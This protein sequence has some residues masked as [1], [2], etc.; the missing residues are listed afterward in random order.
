MRRTRR[1]IYKRTRRVIYK[2][3]YVIAAF[4]VVYIMFQIYLFGSS[5]NP[6]LERHLHTPQLQSIKDPCRRK[7][8][9][10]DS[11]WVAM[12]SWNDKSGLHSAL[13]SVLQ[14]RPSFS[15]VKVVVF[16]DVSENMFSLEEKAKYPSV[17]FLHSTVGAQK[18][19]AYAKWRIFE[20][21]R[22]SSNPND[23]VVVIDGDDVLADAVVF[24]YI[25]D[26]LTSNKP[27]FAWGRINGKF[28]DQ[29]NHLPTDA[30]SIRQYLLRINRFPF[31]HP[32][33]FKSRL[34]Q[35]LSVDDYKNGKGVWL[36]KATDRPFIFEFVER[37]GDSRVRYLSKRK[38]Y[39]Y[40]WT[41]NNGLLLFPKEVIVGDKE[42]VNSMPSERTEVEKIHI[43]TCMWDR[44]S[45]NEFIQKIMSSKIPHGYELILHI[46]NNKQSMLKRRHRIARGFENVFVYDMVENTRGYGRFL[47]ANRIMKT[48]Q[49]EYFIMVDDDMLVHNSTIFDV[50]SKREPRTYKSWYGKNWDIDE[51][52][53]WKP[54]HQLVASRPAVAFQQYPFIKR[55]Q[56]G[57]TGMSIIDASIFQTDVLFECPDKYKQVED[58]WLSYVVRLLHWSIHRLRVEFDINVEES[59]SGQW[60]QMKEL[61]NEAFKDLG[62]LR[63]E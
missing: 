25:H 13:Q 32:R 34:L 8:A 9:L 14:Q 54:K 49:V 40:S 62:F 18:G 5:D 36:Q 10:N 17:V 4:V 57:G 37:S 39:N 42:Y 16:E 58:M 24:K 43:I 31:C 33:M 3:S 2:C 59:M 29:C 55:W 27:W 46:C 38:I 15:H 48:T 19:S 60:S 22:R 50:F 56:Y 7:V 44:I 51:T 20:Y 45:D 12:S 61:K 30:S 26:E 63:C 21:I 41:P 11:L 28:E 47:L 52:D 53:Y 35:T 6:E 23:Y 1:V